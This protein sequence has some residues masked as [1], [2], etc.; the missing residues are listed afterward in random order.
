MTKVERGPVQSVARALGLLDTIAESGEISLSRLATGS[1]LSPSTTHRLLAALVS[2]GYVTQDPVSGWYR[3]GGHL[4]AMAGRIA[5]QLWGVLEGARPYLLELR[6]RYDETVNLV[7]LDG[8]N[9][10]YV[11][12]VESSRPVR[13]FNQVGNSVSLHTS[14]AG[15]ALLADQPERIVAA[16]LGRAPFERLTPTTIVEADVMERELDDIRRLGYALD[17][18]ERDEG[19]VCVAAA[20]ST[21]EGSAR[22]ALSMSGPAERM[23]R[24]HLDEVGRDMA[25]VATEIS[26]AF[27]N[28]DPPL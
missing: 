1:G 17:R 21:S 18:Q 4:R 13:M 8:W 14:A 5:S 22:T 9:A 6:D 23:M 12:Q 20:I 3:V 15:K 10:R 25:R 2:A 11:D 16:Y 28:S 27:G 26:A 19:V 24:L 7:E